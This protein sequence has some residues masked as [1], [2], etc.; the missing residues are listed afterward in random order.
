MKN[1]MYKLFGHKWKYGFTMNSSH[2]VRTDI[3]F[4]ERTGKLQ[5]LYTDPMI[6]N[7][8]PFWMNAVT[9]TKIGAVK[10]YPLQLLKD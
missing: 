1:L 9:Y 10:H 4:C 3:R 8:K 7:G 2:T 6:N 5:Y